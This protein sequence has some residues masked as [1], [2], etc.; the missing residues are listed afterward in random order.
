MSIPLAVSP[1]SA[2]VTHNIAVAW[3]LFVTLNLWD[4]SLTFARMWLHTLILWDIS[5]IFVRMW[6]CTPILWDL[7]LTFARMW[8]HAPIIWDISLIFARMWLHTLILWDISLIFVHMWLSSA[9]HATLSD[10]L[11]GNLLAMWLSAAIC[12]L[13]K[14]QEDG[15]AVFFAQRYIRSV[16]QIPSH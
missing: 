15:R 3:H 5:L 14:L 16:A 7:S 9:Q 6:L 12:L 4:L 1:H 10:M 2:Q 8:L 11:L 13:L